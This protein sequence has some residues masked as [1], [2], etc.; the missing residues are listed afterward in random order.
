MKFLEMHAGTVRRVKLICHS[1]CLLNDHYHFI[2]ETPDGNLSRGMRQVN[3][4][5]TQAFNR[6]Y[7]RRGPLFGE[8]FRSIVFEKSRY[9]LPLNR[10][11]ILNPVRM[12]L[13]PSAEAWYWSSYLPTIGQSERPP[14]LFT[15]AIL[16]WFSRRD[17][18]LAIEGYKAFI[19]S[20]DTER[21]SWRD[22]KFQVFLGSDYFIQ[23]MRGLLFVHKTEKCGKTPSV[24]NGRRGPLKEIF[25]GGWTSRR[26][27]DARIYR[28]YV[29]EGF[30]LQE[31]ADCLGIHTATVSRAVRRVEKRKVC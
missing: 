6:K 17:K 25:D 5:Y 20:G 24:R 3:G 14:F 9:L 10:H 13:V 26:E 22:L 4:L 30:T 15:Q 21:F 19:A 18:A 29:E 2:L 31:I 27:R 28:A 12:G 1:Y 11:M 7:R 8:R 16:S 23:K